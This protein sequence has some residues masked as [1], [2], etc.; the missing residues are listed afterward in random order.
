MDGTGKHR[1][2]WNYPGSEDQNLHV[3]SH[4]QNIDLI[5]TAIL[6]KQVMLRGGHIWEG[7]GKRRKLRRWIW[8]IY[9]LYKNEYRIFKPP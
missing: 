9:S 6:W 7:E 8:F 5:N 2:K 1:L 3:F 4:M